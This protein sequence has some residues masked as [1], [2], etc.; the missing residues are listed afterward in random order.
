M[1]L[2]RCDSPV[3]S[4]PAHRPTALFDRDGVLNVDHGYVADWE[5]FTWVEGAKEAVAECG[6]RGV[7]VGIVTNQS[8]IGRGY[9]TEVQFRHLMDRIADQIS[10]EVAVYCP[11]APE[12]NCSG[13][14]PSPQ[15]ILMAMGFLGSDPART[16]FVGDKPSDRE[17]AERAGVRF[18]N[19][20]GQNLLETITPMLDLVTA[21]ET[22]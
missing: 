9:Y 7:A 20:L 3:H 2:L 4:L 8:G 16:F 13:R 19:F 11:H 6:R 5:R 12:E 15:T 22:S 18:V 10:V 14:K 21:A 17:A 1:Q